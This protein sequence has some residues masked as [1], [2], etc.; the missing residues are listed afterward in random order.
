MVRS[1][2]AVI[3][4]YNDDVIVILIYFDL[5]TITNPQQ[6]KKTKT[7][8]SEEAKHSKIFGI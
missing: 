8:N 1:S 5:R 7:K 3:F 6:Q 2:P 4:T